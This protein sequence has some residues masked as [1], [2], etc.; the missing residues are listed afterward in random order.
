MARILIIEDDKMLLNMYELKL[1][2]AGVE[3]ITA[4]DGASGLA[5]AK[6]EKPDLILLDIILPKMDGFRVLKAIKE[7][8]EIKSKPVLMITNL[9]Q[10]EDI[11]KGNALGAAGYLIKASTPPQVLVEEINK[12]LA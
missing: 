3:V 8:E 9:G 7:D 11:Q 6:S 5:L 10:E 1:K 4:A 2:G 12:K